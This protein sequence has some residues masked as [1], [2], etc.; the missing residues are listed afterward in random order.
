MDTNAARRA[1]AESYQKDLTITCVV[2]PTE[3]A[4]SDKPAQDLLGR[5]TQRNMQLGGYFN[6]EHLCFIVSKPDRS[7]KVSRYIGDHPNMKKALAPVLAKEKTFT[8]SHRT[9]KIEIGTIRVARVSNYELI[10]GLN[11]EI[12]RLELILNNPLSATLQKRKREVEDD[13]AGIIPHVLTP[14]FPQLTIKC[15]Q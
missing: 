13:Q 4:S 1:I 2:A 11:E 7:L 9:I 6:G 10:D 3:R 12:R 15:S 14:C 5:A 8:E